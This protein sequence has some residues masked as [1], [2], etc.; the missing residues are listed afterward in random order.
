MTLPAGVQAID[1]N[2]FYHCEN[3]TEVTLPEGLKEI[4]SFAFY[5][6]A[7]LRRVVL[8][9]GLKSIGSAAF[10][11]CPSLREV[12][13]PAGLERIDADAFRN[14]GALERADLPEGLKKIGEKAFFKCG[15]LKTLSLPE[16]MVSVGE[17]AFARCAGL[18]ALKLPE[19]LTQIAKYGFAACSGLYDKNSMLI[20]NRRLCG[21]RG[22]SQSVKVP[23]GIVYIEPG[24]FGG[25]AHLETSLNCP[26]WTA[27]ERVMGTERIRP[28]LEDDGSTVAFRDETGAVAAKVILP[29][30]NETYAKQNALRL[31]IRQKDG[32]FDFAGY[33]ACFAG[34]KEKN[35]KIRMALIRLDLPYA[36][37]EA[38]ERQYASFLKR[39]LPE[40]AE[41]L[42]AEG[43]PQRLMW[44]VER[45]EP[46]EKSVQALVEAAH[47]CESPEL[48]A[49]LL[50][51]QH[52]RFR[53]PGFADLFTLDIPSP[54]TDANGAPRNLWTLRGGAAGLV[55]R[56]RGYET[57]IEFPTVVRGVRVR[58]IADADTAVPDNYKE[59]RAVTLPEGYASIGKNAFYGCVKLERVELPAS[60]TDVDARAFEGCMS[61]K[62]LYFRKKVSFAGCPFVGAKIGTLIIETDPRKL[63]PPNLLLGCTVGRLVYYGGRF[64]ST[65]YVFG[66]GYTY[67]T[68]VYCGGPFETSDA[69]DPVFRGSGSSLS[70]KEFDESTLDSPLL[71]AILAMEKRKC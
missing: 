42:I 50:Q 60:L 11:E 35:N 64:V 2:A 55:N 14:C 8:P 54:D 53:T 49:W 46:S 20:V 62:Q 48:M 47:A 24:I 39:H 44:L 13:F 7:S 23:D 65:G 1:H 59:L 69:D 29:I 61:L 51:Y 58:G 40:T 43:T 3:L 36:L 27:T 15:K 30:K 57:E 37:S 21:Y 38:A 16:S 25:F 32:R 67:P 56:Y 31:A 34:L 4:G 70:L 66:K 12:M 5:G 33:D 19:H 17:N 28:L 22:R 6:C 26:D 18:T 71:R 45:L 9:Q 41:M 10:S 52:E 68:A 63:I